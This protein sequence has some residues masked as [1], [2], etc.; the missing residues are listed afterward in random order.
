MGASRSR[1]RFPLN[2][3]LPKGGLTVRKLDQDLAASVQC[4]FKNAI[5]LL[6]ER[7]RKQSSATRLCLAGGLALNSVANEP[8]I[9]ETSFSD[10]HII[11][12]ADDAGVAIGA[13]YYGLW[14]G[15]GRFKS[16]KLSSD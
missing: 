14:L 6:G 5:L 3:K 2:F 1:T 10:V 9:S 4:A 15:G 12:A 16:S 11:P 8:I 13:A 7:L